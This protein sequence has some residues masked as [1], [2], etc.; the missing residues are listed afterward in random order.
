[1]QKF[2]IKYHV[3]TILVTQVVVLLVDCMLFILNSYTDVKMVGLTQQ[4]AIFSSLGTMI[5]LL[6]LGPVLAFS[7]NTVSPDRIGLEAARTSQS[8]WITY[9]VQYSL[10]ISFVTAIVHVSCVQILQAIIVHYPVTANLWLAYYWTFQT[11]AIVQLLGLL[12]TGLVKMSWTWNV[13]AIYMA[14]VVSSRLD[15]LQFFPDIEAFTNFC[16][17]S[18]K[19]YLISFSYGAVIGICT[20]ILLIQL[21]DWLFSKKETYTSR[22]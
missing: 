20:I 15:S 21:N 7:L 17:S 19:N 1:M 4:T 10:L 12:L 22:E 5:F 16:V 2:F 6:A 8:S 3:S 13:I 18:S 11:F 9:C 14:L